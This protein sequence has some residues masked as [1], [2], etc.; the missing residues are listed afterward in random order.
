MSLLAGFYDVFLVAQAPRAQ[1]KYKHAMED[2]VFYNAKEGYWQAS[3]MIMAMQEFK[4]TFD[5]FYGVY[6][7]P[8]VVIGDG[9]IQQ[10]DYGD[11]GEGEVMMKKR[12]LLKVSRSFAAQSTKYIFLV[13]RVNAKENKIIDVVLDNVAVTMYPDTKEK[14]YD[15]RIGQAKSKDES[16]DE[17]NK[18]KEKEKQK[19]EQKK[20]EEKEATDKNE[21]QKGDY[22]LNEE[23]EKEKEKEKKQATDKED[24]ELKE[25]KEK[26]KNDVFFVIPKYYVTKTDEGHVIGGYAL[27]ADWKPGDVIDTAAISDDEN[28][29]SLEFILL[30]FSCFD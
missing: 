7:D 23:K 29:K 17:Q 27:P 11:D 14:I 4:L 22:K 1:K 6:G 18:E 2:S 28:I 10:Y 25:E 15:P 20:D 16:K 3:D 9:H 19:V 5:Y 26:K 24:Y 30:Q 13:A 12:G 21:V 8:D